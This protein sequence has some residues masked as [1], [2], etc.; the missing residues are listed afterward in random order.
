[1][2]IGVDGC[3]YLLSCQMQLITETFTWIKALECKVS[4][5]VGVATV[6]PVV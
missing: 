4:G 5:G 1:M 3:G 2:S 6:A